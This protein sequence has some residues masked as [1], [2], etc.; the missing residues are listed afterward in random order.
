MDSETERKIDEVMYETNDKIN[1]I[2]AEI[3]QIRFSKMPEDEKRVKCDELRE[4]FEEVMIEE[5]KKIEE[6]MKKNSDQ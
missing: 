2:V 6:I 1:A 5:E 3:R 4:K